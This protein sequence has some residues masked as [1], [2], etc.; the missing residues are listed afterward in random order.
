MINSS[1]QHPI[2]DLVAS[3]RTRTRVDHGEGLS[4]QRGALGDAE[5][6]LPVLLRTPQTLDIKRMS[7]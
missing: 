3:A 1:F 2:K 6:E 5:E 4:C 7:D